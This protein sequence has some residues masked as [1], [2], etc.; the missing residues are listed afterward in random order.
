MNDGSWLYEGY[1]MV[2]E[3]NASSVVSAAMQLNH[4]NLWV[5]VGNLPFGALCP[6]VGEGI[7]KHLGELIEYDSRNTIQN[8]YMRL[9]VHMDVSVPLKQA[10]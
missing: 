8:S 3:C 6:D 9:K 1:S 5:H 4:L 10:W 7:G 2:L